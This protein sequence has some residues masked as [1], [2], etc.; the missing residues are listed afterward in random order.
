MSQYGPVTKGT[1]YQ[2]RKK[3][4]KMKPADKVEA[5]AWIALPGWA[6]KLAHRPAT[7]PSVRALQGFRTGFGA[8]KTRLHEISI[9]GGIY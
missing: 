4:T 1:P 2:Q 8:H 3:D 6:S 5:E 9:R 7:R